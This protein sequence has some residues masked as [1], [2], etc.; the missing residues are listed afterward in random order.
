MPGTHSDNDHS[1]I[2]ALPFAYK[3]VAYQMIRSNTLA[4]MLRYLKEQDFSGFKEVEKYETVEIKTVQKTIYACIVAKITSFSKSLCVNHNQLQ[5]L[6]ETLFEA[7][8]VLLDTRNSDRPFLHTLLR[9]HHAKTL[10]W[11]ER[12]AATEAKSSALEIRLRRHNNRRYFRYH[13]SLS[14]HFVRLGSHEMV[15]EV[16]GD[17]YS[18]GIQH[19][20]KVMNKKLDSIADYYTKNIGLALQKS[21]AQAHQLFMQVLEK[22]ES[23]REI[24]NGISLGQLNIGSAVRSLQENMRSPLDYASLDGNIRTEQILKDFADKLNQIN[25]NTL[26]LLEKSTPHKLYSGPVLGKLKI[27]YD[28]KGYI[29][30]NKKTASS[31]LQAFI[32]LYHYTLLMEKV[33]NNISSSHYV[34]IFPEYWSKDF[35]DISPGGFAFYSEFLVNKNDILELYFNIDFSKTE[36]PEY[37]VIKQKA[38]VVRVEEHA[39]MEKYLIAC[40]FIMCPQ[41]T[42]SLIS[43][44]IQG[45]EVKDAFHAL[46]PSN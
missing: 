38:K 22:L 7:L 35:K 1:F 32:D 26:T 10:R 46:N 5:F 19:F 36:Q 15:D 37:E 14:Y 12:D 40:E 17:I 24:L 18:S 3:K 31:L 34:I 13:S 9:T 33:Y 30:K 23:L 39:E 4:T 25:S 41:K 29:E 2:E 8:K 21:H 11:I 43:N 28:I 16:I 27:D 44:A 20:N 45:Q 6:D 42:I